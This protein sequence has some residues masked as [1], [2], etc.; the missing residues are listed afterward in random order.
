MKR[1]HH[2]PYH[3]HHHHHQYHN[4]KSSRAQTSPTRPITITKIYHTTGDRV[5]NNLTKETIRKAAKRIKGK[6]NMR[7]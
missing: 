7:F 3:H 2:H 1:N 6:S 5:K 4:Q